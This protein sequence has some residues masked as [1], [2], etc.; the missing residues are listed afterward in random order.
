MLSLTAP[1]EYHLH[2]RLQG[3]KFK[4]YWYRVYIGFRTNHHCEVDDDDDE[5]EIQQSH[6]VSPV[7]CTQCTQNERVESGPGK[8][9]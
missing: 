8:V 3:F 1:V 5:L 6:D 9:G 7:G 4:A 2:T